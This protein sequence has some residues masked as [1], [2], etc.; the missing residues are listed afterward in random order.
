[1]P[2]TEQKTILLVEDVALI[3]LTETH[4]IKTFGY[5]VVTA[6]TGEA[7]VELALKDPAISLILMDIDLGEGIDGTEAARRILRVR[8]VPIVFLTSHAEREMVERVRGIT[9]YGYVLKDSGEFVL[10]SSIEMAFE[11]FEANLKASESERLF[12]SLVSASSQ[13][14]W[15]VRTEGVPLD[16]IHLADAAWWREFT[17]QTEEERTACAGMGWL[18]AVHEGDRESARSY[19]LGIM[20][21]EGPLD[22]EYRV[23]RRDGEWRW[24]RVQGVPILD[25]Q[26]RLV[27]KAG[28]ATDITDRR[29][30]EEALQRSE[31][32][33]RARADD[34]AAIM[35]AMPAITFIAHDPQCLSMTSSRAAIE[36]LRLKSDANT[37]LSAPAAERPRNFRPLQNGRELRPEE[38]PA[39]RAAATGETIRD[40]ELT[41]AFEDGGQAVILGNAVPL[42]DES[43][44]PRGAVGSFLDITERRKAG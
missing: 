32:E 27:E 19:W 17:G 24:L 16:G 8:Q 18:D 35:D 2:V 9:R 43:G 12:H 21:A 30:V 29:R 37:S 11:L 13:T 25:G 26:G 40:F 44:K 23:R 34:L 22:T 3:A 20:E 39:Q 38:L 5:A 10:R 6:R 31:A 28:T 15:R 4:M 36:F 7:A 42:L 1:M 41:L 14:V 33:A